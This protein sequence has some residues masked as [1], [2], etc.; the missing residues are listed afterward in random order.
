MR[1]IKREI[2]RN[3]EIQNAFLRHNPVLTQVTLV[4][5]RDKNL[6]FLNAKTMTLYRRRTGG[7][8]VHCVRVTKSFML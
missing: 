5:D 1:K 2:K 3:W 8:G 4:E 6:S 7:S